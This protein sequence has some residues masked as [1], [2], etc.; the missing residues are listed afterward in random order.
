MTNKVKH[1]KIPLMISQSSVTTEINKTGS[2][3]FVRPVYDEKTAPCSAAC[4][5]GED[6]PYIEMLT[7]RKM[8]NDALKTLIIENPFPAVCGRVC[9][10]PCEFACNRA[11][12]D[13]PVNIHRIERFLGD[14]SLENGIDL[15]QFKLANNGKKICIAGSGPAGLSAAYFLTLLGYSCDIFE[16]GPEPGGI[17][18][19]GIP[20][21]R[22][23][24]A[25][26]KKEIERITGTGVKIHCEK[27]V[28]VS[29]LKKNKNIYNAFFIGCGLGRS[30]QMNIPGEEFAID[31]LGFLKRVKKEKPVVSG[32]TAAVIGGGNTA[33]DVA[34]SLVRCGIKPVIVYRRRKQDMPAFKD[35]VQMALNEGVEIMELVAPVKIDKVNNEFVLSLQPMKVAEYKTA[36]GRARVAPEREK[37]CSFNFNMVY[38]A[39]GAEPAG[40]WMVL[41][42][43][44]KNSLALDHCTI[45]STDIPQV[46]GGDLTNQN[47]S[48]THAIASGKEAALSL[49]IMLKDGIDTVSDRLAF[50]KVGKG[51]AL[52]M[53]KYMEK[54]KIKRNP[55]IVSY[56]EINI[57]YFSPCSRLEPAY[58]LDEKRIQSFAQIE[59]TFSENNVINETE[60]CFNCGICNEC[61]NCRIFCPDVAVI[62][63]GTGRRINLDYC[64]GCGICVAECPRN[65]MALEEE[66]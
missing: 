19:W 40:S 12:F 57:D 27:P 61:D 45:K 8:Y 10:H 7:N 11:N 36:G 3:R 52:S 39:I 30:M 17:M 16:A 25:V 6:I 62:I 63:D 9:F 35:E 48:V 66:I 1:S 53:K 42:E 46:Y 24:E 47:K 31:G 33:V 23:P 37:T 5:V 22:L 65:A 38:T 2:W 58:L 60:R 43:K 21:Y 29:F 41:P 49:D 51:P 44:E 55:H 54:Q 28:T 56:Q 13:E 15:S 32:G 34:R 14:Y 18:R 59:Q 50:L 26:L 64:K 20:E 4:P